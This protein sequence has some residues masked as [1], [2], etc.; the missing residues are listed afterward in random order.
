MKKISEFLFILLSLLLKIVCVY[1]IRS[2]WV[3]RRQFQSWDDGSGCHQGLNAVQLSTL[4]SSTGPLP[5]GLQP[6]ICKMAAARLTAYI[7]ILGRNNGKEQRWKYFLL[8]RLCCLF[9]KACFPSW[10][11]WESW[12]RKFD[13]FSLF[14]KGGQGHGELWIV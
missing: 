6:H 2:I 8:V 9:R 14:D 4:L 1:I 7:H 5:S 11:K 13:L 3:W 10:S 12:N